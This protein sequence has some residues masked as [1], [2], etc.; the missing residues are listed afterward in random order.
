[1]TA[2]MTARFRLLGASGL[3]L[4]GL[5]CAG[6]AGGEVPP[7]A[8]TSWALTE[9]RSGETAQIT[10][11][12][13]PVTL[14]FLDGGN[15]LTGSSGCNGYSGTYETDGAALRVLALEITERACPTQDLLQREMQYEGI[16]SSARTFVLEGERLTIQGDNGAAL[17]FGPRSTPE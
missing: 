10:N 9:M 15:E 16:L 5:A 1:M 3:L 4:L 7:L 11:T 6:C 12:D 8:A 17:V 13:V 2:M 14:E